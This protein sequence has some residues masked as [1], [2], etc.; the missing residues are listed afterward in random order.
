VNN[1]LF[2]QREIPLK[3]R[4]VMYWGGLRGAISLALALTLTGEV[5][6]TAVALEL[7]VMTFGVVLFTLLGQGTTI[8]RLIDRLKLSKKPIQ[9]VEQQR[10]Q[11]VLYAKWAGRHELER[12]QTEG[13]LFRDIGEAM[14]IVYDEEIKQL[15]KDLRQHLQDYP[16][17]EQEMLLQ[18]RVDV[19]RAERSAIGDANRRGFLSE[20]LYMEL[21]RE[22][23]KRAA[24]LDL[25]KTQRSVTAA[26]IEYENGDE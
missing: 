15:K 6:G 18:A 2:P 20:E 19:L 8:E 11:A 7:R 21:I 10:Q 13:I 5:F 12:L 1:R 22:A 26:A 25:V 3:Y 24:A 17:L 23:D 14:D 4:H 9:A 16:E